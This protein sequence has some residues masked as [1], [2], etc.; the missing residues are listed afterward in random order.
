MLKVAVTGATGFIGRRFIEYNRNRFRL[1]M[2]TLRNRKISD[3]DLRG[4]DVVVHFAG[5]AHDM[6]GG[7]D[8]D[9]FKI[10][11]ELTKELAVQAIKQGVSQFVYISSVKVYGEEDGVILDE[12][13]ECHPVDAYG[14]S[15][16]LAEQW[17]WT[18][19]SP[20]FRIAVIR[21]SL[22]YGPGVKGNMINLLK[23]ADR[24]IPLPFGRI[25]NMRSMVFLDNLV[26]LINKVMEDRAYGIFVAADQEPVSTSRLVQLIRKFLGRRSNLLYLPGPVRKILKGYKPSLYKRL[27]GSFV[28]GNKNNLEKLSFVPPYTTEYG[29]QKMVEWYKKEKEVQK[30]LPIPQREETSDF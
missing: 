12:N 9:Y 1:K 29:L 21:P 19:Q 3:I 4:A 5:K 7:N 28:I 15:K 30:A 8:Q 20:T 17:L 10:N 25:N 22:V 14:K 18:V 6:T 2:I 23:L 27:F 13:T 16:L 11:T 24:A 26:E